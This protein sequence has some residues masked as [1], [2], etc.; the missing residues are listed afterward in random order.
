L[1]RER[2]K[3]GRGIGEVETTVVRQRWKKRGTKREK[4]GE[5]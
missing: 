2:G 3:G 5:A 1:E 4:K